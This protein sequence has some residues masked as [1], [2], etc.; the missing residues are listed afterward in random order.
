MANLPPECLKTCPPFTY[1]GLDVFGPWSIT[2]RR[3]RGGWAESKQWAIMCSCLS[4]RAVHIELIESMD[5]SSCINAL[6][7]FFALRGPAKQL[8][9]DCGTNFVGASKELGMDKT[10]E[11]P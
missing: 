11:L 1:V 9:S 10:A 2:T 6:W 4:L 3:T 8:R 5:S 7:R